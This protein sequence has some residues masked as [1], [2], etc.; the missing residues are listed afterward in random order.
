MTFIGPSSKFDLYMA[1][2]GVCT[3]ERKMDGRGEQEGGE[4]RYGHE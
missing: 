3:Q 2:K 1:K 4:S